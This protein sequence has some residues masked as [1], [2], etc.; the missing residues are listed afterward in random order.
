MHTLFKFH[1]FVEYLAPTSF[2]RQ[3]G[4]MFSHFIHISTIRPL[5]LVYCV[6]YLGLNADKYYKERNLND[7]NSIATTHK[8]KPIEV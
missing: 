3:H 1:I 8:T 4:Y 6:L 2:A 5:P 7:V